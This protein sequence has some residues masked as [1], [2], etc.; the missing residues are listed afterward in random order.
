MKFK[1]LILVAAAVAVAGMVSS[2]SKRAEE[3]QQEETVS[4]TGEVDPAEIGQAVHV[5]KADEAINPVEGKLV[6]I[7]FNATWCGPCKQFGPVFEK[8]AD[9]NKEKAL[10][11]SVDVDE[12]PGL[13]AKYQVH[14]IPMVV[15]IA[16]TGE[17]TSSVGYMDEATFAAEVASRLPR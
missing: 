5:V 4:A 11:Y 13:A 7:D 3:N 9:A 12:N 2:C 1:S 16:P 15:Y 10:F 14:S 6:V 17:T 8:V